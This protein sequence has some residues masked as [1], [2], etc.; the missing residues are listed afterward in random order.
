MLKAQTGAIVIIIIVVLI[1]KQSL[2]QLYCSLGR[3]WDRALLELQVPT[4][5]TLYRLG[6]SPFWN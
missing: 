4:T 2:L 1:N 6:P 5:S 3:S